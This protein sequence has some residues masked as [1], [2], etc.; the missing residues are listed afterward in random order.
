MQRINKRMKP[1]SFMSL[2]RNALPPRSIIPKC[3]L[4]SLM[5]INGINIINAM[6][7]FS[8]YFC[9]LSNL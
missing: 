8:M 1:K 7:I 3:I 9:H 2:I 4:I 5:F 6:T